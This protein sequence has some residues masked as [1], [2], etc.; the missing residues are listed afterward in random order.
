MEYKWRRSGFAV[1]QDLFGRSPL[2]KS[3][4]TE[5][6]ICWRLQDT[7]N[8]MMAELERAPCSAT[9]LS[10]ETSVEGTSLATSVDG[11]ET[12]CSTRNTSTSVS[13]ARPVVVVAPVPRRAYAAQRRTRQEA[14]PRH[15]ESSSMPLSLHTPLAASAASARTVKSASCK[16]LTTTARA[17]RT[18]SGTSLF[19]LL[20]LSTINDTHLKAFLFNRKSASSNSDVIFLTASTRSSKVKPRNKSCDSWMARSFKFL[21]A[22]TKRSTATKLRSG[23]WSESTFPSLSSNG[24]FCTERLTQPNSG[25][26]PW[27]NLY[28][29][30]SLTNSTSSTTEPVLRRPH[31]L[32]FMFMPSRTRIPLFSPP[33]TRHKGSFCL[34]RRSFPLVNF[35]LTHPE[36]GPDPEIFSNRKRWEADPSPSRNSNSFTTAP[37]PSRSEHSSERT[38]SPLRTT[39]PPL[40][41]P[42]TTCQKLLGSDMKTPTSKVCR[43]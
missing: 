36:L 8:F 38:S 13:V 12:P 21:N 11:F 2:S 29:K 19:S 6:Q 41:P 7:W 17:P 37:V 33:T 42:P 35:K 43:W 39:I 34:R 24:F 4:H 32:E 26:A 20:S 5:L 3:V 25:P 30:R 18:I 16:P 10:W 28:L 1:S 27:S 23:S 15:C 9:I 40:S 22:K 14:S 31:S